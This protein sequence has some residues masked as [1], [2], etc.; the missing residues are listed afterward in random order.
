MQSQPATH[1]EEH[2]TAAEE[3]SENRD[4]K[5]IMKEAI[6]SHLHNKIIHFPLALGLTASVL[7]FFHANETRDD[8]LQFGFC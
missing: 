5:T 7:I 6:W 8:Y 3:T 2:E 1:E 4:P